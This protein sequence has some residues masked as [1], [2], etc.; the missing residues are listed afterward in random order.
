[1]S[2]F[3]V[4]HSAEEWQAELQ[5]KFGLAAA[6]STLSVG[7]FDGL[8]LGHQ[9]ILRAVVERAR[10]T[11]T[12]A[13]VVT[14]DPHPLKVLRPTQAPPLVETLP[15]R[16]N[17][18]QAMGLDAALVLHF[19]MA[20][21]ALSAQEFVRG[22]LVDKLHAAA[23]LVGQT[24]RFGHNNAGDVALL[25]DMGRELQFDVEIIPPV[26]LDGQMVSSTAVRQAVLEGRPGEATR[27]LGRPFALIGQIAR[28]SG[29]GSTIVVPTLNLAPEQ[30]LLPKTGVYT[31]QVL[32]ARQ[33]YNAVTNVGFRPTFDG[34]R[35][36]IESHLFDFSERL[37]EGRL[38]VRF[39]ERLRDEQK[40]NGPQQLVKQISSDI[41]RAREFFR[42][43]DP[44][45][46]AR[47]PA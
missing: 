47:Q 8:H 23:I 9:K 39:R 12:V 33:L 3:S 10:A 45:P 19:D 16:M 2:K 13:S 28:G 4:L 20:F 36:S 25:G 21:A 7:N 42:R 17:G 24:F 41:E 15:Q 11:N 38:E 1:V 6:R 43:L 44:G 32:V 35:L 27:L 26:V 40:F 14:F 29:R 31:T 37:T 22:V 18:L 34:T 30:E 46:S 5:T